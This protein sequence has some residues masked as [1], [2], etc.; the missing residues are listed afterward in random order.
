M[1]PKR[2]SGA[3]RTK[4]SHTRNSLSGST[5]T[6]TRDIRPPPASVAL[7]RS[8]TLRGNSTTTLTNIVLTGARPEEHE[9]TYSRTR[10]QWAVREMATSPFR[11]P[12]W[13]GLADWP[14]AVRAT[15]RRR[16]R[17]IGPI[18]SWPGRRS[19]GAYAGTLRRT[20]T[21]LKGA[22][23]RAPPT[24]SSLPLPPTFHLAFTERQ[25]A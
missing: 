10:G 17:P 25:L 24:F 15:A 5:G 9:R 7:N 1:L 14:A 18:G 6:C 3:R 22:K 21:L 11:A 23:P 2:R 16:H 12:R 20:P 4:V 8:S 19:T 13:H